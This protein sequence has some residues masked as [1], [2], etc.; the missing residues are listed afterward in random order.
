M[1]TYK[2]AIDIGGTFTDCLLIDSEGNSDVFKVLTTSSNPSS[3]VFS[4]LELMKNSQ[5]LKSMADFL[6]RVEVIVHGTT[7]TTNAVLTKDGAKTED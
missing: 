6:S 4:G 1:I 3:A 7:I 5:G 2:I